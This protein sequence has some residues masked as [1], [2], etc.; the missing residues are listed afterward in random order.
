MWSNIAMGA[1]VVLLTLVSG[2]GERPI[3]WLIVPLAAWLFFSPFV[4][5]FA[6]KVFFA[7]NIIMA[8][9]VIAGAAA[10]EEIHVARVS[11]GSPR[12]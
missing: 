10:S 6:G 5:G 8:F 1:A 11:R 2:S 12:S 3:Q 7:N 9:V 4:L